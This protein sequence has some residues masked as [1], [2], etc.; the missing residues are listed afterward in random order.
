MTSEPPAK[1]IELDC[2]CKAYAGH[3]VLDSA[4]LEVGG[5]EAVAIL[6]RSG[7]GKSTLLKLI[8]GLDTPD[9]GSVVHA[10]RSLS[11]MSDRERT[12][13][14]RET[15]GFVFQFFNLIPTLTVAENVRLPLALNGVGEAQTRQRA[16]R[17]LHG[18]GLADCLDRFPDEISGGEQQ[19]VAIARALVH[20]PDLIIADEPTGNLDVETAEQVLAVLGAACRER[21]TTLLMA[22]HSSD[23]AAT[24]DRVVRIRNGRIEEVAR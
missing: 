17:L 7:S 18:L 5:G 15:L 21:R 2:V 24:A 10:G 1:Q 23:V 13:F 12:R 6:G 14:R 11:A 4:S 19:R 16:E 9:S 8:G 20:E 3:R 22:T